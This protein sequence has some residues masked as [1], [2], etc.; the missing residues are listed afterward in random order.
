MAMTP[1]RS[2]ACPVCATAWIE[3]ACAESGVALTPLEQR[4]LI[5]ALLSH[6]HLIVSGPAGI[7]K[8]RLIQALAQAVTQGR[9]EYVQEIQGHPWWAAR[10]GDVARFVDLQT[11]FSVWRL[12]T[13][14]ESALDGKDAHPI[15]EHVACIQ[16]MSPVEVSIY[17]EKFLGWLTARVS[18]QPLRLFGTYDSN[19]QP[20]VANQ[21]C[22]QFSLVHLNPVQGTDAGLSEN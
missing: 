16:R 14:A 2:A 21:A 6:R 1:T 20:L 18:N 5:A 4:R 13:F 12:L 9:Q 8:E 17:F 3:Q 10:T 22:P 15:Q 7:G 19:V 11:E